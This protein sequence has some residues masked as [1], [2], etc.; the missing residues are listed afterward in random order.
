MNKKSRKSV[1]RFYTN[2]Y[3]ARLKTDESISEKKNR[4]IKSWIKLKKYEKKLVQK[5]YEEYIHSICKKHA[6]HIKNME[7]YLKKKP[8][9]CLSGDANVSISNNGTEVS[10][11]E[12]LNPNEAKNISHAEMN[13]SCYS[14]QT[15][16]NNVSFTNRNLLF[17]SI[18]EPD[19]PRFKTAKD[20]YIMLQSRDPSLGESW[21]YLP[22]ITKK[23]YHAALSK[24]RKEYIENYI[25]YLQSKPSKFLYDLLQASEE[26]D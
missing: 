22:D 5:K 15:E 10:F 9:S 8:S 13:A 18:P 16:D 24:I 3:I 26:S 17:E 4:A 23:R 19:P 1:L 25:K 7:P 6:E 20:L 11:D 21:L 14:N 2:L 12:I